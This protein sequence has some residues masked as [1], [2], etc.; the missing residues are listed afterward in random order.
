MKLKSHGFR[1]DS[2]Q[3]ME[4]HHLNLVSLLHPSALLPTVPV[5]LQVS[6]VWGS[7][8]AP[9]F[10]RHSR[11][12]EGLSPSR[13]RQNSQDCPLVP[14]G[15]M[16]MHEPV[17]VVRENSG[18]HLDRMARHIEKPRTPERNSF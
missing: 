18:L 17:T 7:P 6:G 10:H 16:L 3:D 11:K 9:S 4:Q 8:A 2:Y 1:V 15:H 5:P 12:T 14:L 13:I